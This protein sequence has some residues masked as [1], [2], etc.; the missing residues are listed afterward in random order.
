MTAHKR[1]HTTAHTN[2]Q[3]LVLEVREVS[4]GPG[5]LFLALAARRRR[6]D[7]VAGATETLTVADV[8]WRDLAGVAEPAYRWS[9]TG[10]ARCR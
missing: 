6:E 7:L 8:W 2:G 3:A 5:G 10:C 9:R 4:A 1:A